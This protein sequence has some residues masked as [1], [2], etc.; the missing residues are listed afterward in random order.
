MR[1]SLIISLGLH[2]AI[3]ASLAMVQPVMADGFDLIVQA[4]GGGKGKPGGGGDSDEETGATGT[5]Q[6]WMNGEIQGAWDAGYLGQS[7]TITVVDD[8]N[9][10]WGYYGD[11][12]NGTELLRHGE[13]TLM[14]A[15]MIAPGATMVADE[16]TRGGSVKLADGFNVLNLSYG[17]YAT[18][19]YDVD[20]LLFGKQ[21]SSIISYAENGQAVISKAAGNDAVAVGTGNSD[22]LEDYL[23]TALIGA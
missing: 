17:I 23:A 15:S 16:F 20:Q 21:E 7:V 10:S 8:F 9:S 11:L 6:T 2:A 1:I 22:N 3:A 19:G 5:L 14:E 12:G 4:P 18:T 13:W